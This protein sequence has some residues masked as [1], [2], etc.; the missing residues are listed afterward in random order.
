MWTSWVQ[1]QL[2]HLSVFELGISHLITVCLCFFDKNKGNNSNY[3]FV[4]FGQLKEILIYKQYTY[5]YIVCTCSLYICIY[6]YIQVLVHVFTCIH[7]YTLNIQVGFYY[8]CNGFSLYSF[9]FKYLKI[10][11][12]NKV[13]LLLTFSLSHWKPIQQSL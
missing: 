2:Y 10:D 3:L 1:S 7:I 4:F 9:R 6:L 12:E 13:T 5:Q 8:N 11:T